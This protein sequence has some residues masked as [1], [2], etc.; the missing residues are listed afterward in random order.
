MR[1]AGSFLLLLMAALFI[2]GCSSDGTLV[3]IPEPVAEEPDPDDPDAPPQVILSSVSVIS[4]SN[5]LQSDGALPVTVT[6]RV[7]D[8]SNIA[9]EGID[10]AFAAD[11]G[12]LT[13]ANAV[14]DASGRVTATLSTE[15]DPTNR[16]IT[17]TASAAGIDGVTLTG[18]ATVQVIGTEFSPIAG[19]AS[20]VIGATQDYS[21]VL[22]DGNGNGIAGIPI[23]VTSALG[24]PIAPDTLETNFE[25]NVD[26]TLTAQNGG[27][28]QL[29]VSGL[30]IDRTLALEIS[31]DSFV[32]SSPTPPNANQ[33]PPR[34]AL[35]ANQTISVRWETSG[36]PVDGQPVQFSTTRGT[37]ANN[38]QVFTVNGVATNT[39]SSTN[40]GRAVI[41]ATADVEDG[42]SAQIP[43]DFIAT[44]PD[45][46]EVQADPFNIGPNEQSAIRATVRDPQNNLVTDQT[47]IFE[48]DDVTN[49]RLTVGT[50][51]TNTQGEA[52]TFYEASS[53]TSA[54]E[55][56]RIT[57]RV[58]NTN[59]TDTTA[60]TV[61]RRELFFTFG[62][63]NTVLEVDDATYEL[64]FL[65]QASDADGNGVAGVDIQL[66]LLTE[67]YIKGYWVGDAVANAWFVETNVVCDEEDQNRNGFLDPGEDINNNGEIDVGNNANITGTATTDAT[68]EALVAISYAQQFGSWLQVIVEARAE[69][70][71]SSFSE[72]ASFILPTIASDTNSVQISPPGN[73]VAEDPAN[74]YPNGTTDGLITGPVSP[75]GYSQSCFDDI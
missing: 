26:F 11:S 31:T 19:P 64:P 43:I 25:G 53:S 32:F 23:T 75:F 37:L 3:V 74:G 20:I 5:I 55:G 14:T 62:T 22:I 52:Q 13:V 33:D 68:G 48:L 65:V 4:S 36:A 54:S 24:N 63:G 46:I 72:T 70:E 16:V 57:A 47:V 29:T 6:A 51:V 10:V 40:A 69:V 41:T 49:G 30:G 38:G 73:R 18:T 27:S 2:V 42:P 1:K 44:Q 9:V 58:Q 59:I 34:V 21:T 39:I 56:V 45:S 50:A 12:V 66:S 35:N 60:L 8:E 71:G 61:A 7:I 15:E 28:D 17:V 67:R